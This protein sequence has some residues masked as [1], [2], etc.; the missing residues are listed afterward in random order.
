MV[1]QVKL[2][3]G[4]LDKEGFKK[5][6]GEINTWLAKPEAPLETSK[7]RN[8]AVSPVGEKTLVVSVWYE[9]ASR[10]PIGPTP[11]TTGGRRASAEMPGG[12]PERPGRY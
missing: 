3:S 6:E 1:I 7:L 11:A 8:V 4:Q 5:L 10:A 9:T 2:F 12:P